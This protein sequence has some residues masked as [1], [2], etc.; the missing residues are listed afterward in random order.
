MKD[1]FPLVSVII[2]LYNCE[3]FLEDTLLSLI[4]QDYQN[5]EA[6]IID[7]FSSD[8]SLNIAR[9]FEKLDSRFK[10]FSNNVNKGAALTRN[11]AVQK[12]AGRFIAF[13]DSDDIWTKEKL[14]KQ[15]YYM[16]ENNISFSCTN[17]G[18]INEKGEILP[19]II[20]SRKKSNFNNILFNPPGNLTV[21]YDSYLIGKFYIQDIKKRN[22]YLMWLTIIKKATMLNGLN[23]VL[24]YHRLRKGSISSDKISLV[25]YHWYIYT[26][27]F[28]FNFF[29][30]SLI[31]FVIFLKSS[32]QMVVALANSRRKI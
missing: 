17:Y 13:L 7:D 20:R 24:A 15:I 16:I 31:L 1:S 27:I 22:D 29:K 21:I 6:I 28:G 5:W 32:L 12:A 10:V 19:I 4:S 30:S 23:E 14:S 25:K 26:S 11:L 3:L 2:P 8:N 9:K 18:K